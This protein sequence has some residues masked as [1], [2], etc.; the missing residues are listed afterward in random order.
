MIKSKFLPILYLSACLSVTSCSSQATDILE[1]QATSFCVVYDPSNW[2]FKTRNIDRA[3]LYN[4][5][6][7]NAQSAIQAPELKAVFAGYVAS[8]AGTDFADYIEAGFSQVLDSPWK[9]KPMREFEK[10][11]AAPIGIHAQND[12]HQNSAPIKVII[13]Q[14]GLS[15]N[16]TPLTDVTPESI[17]KA[18]S[19][20]LKDAS[21]AHEAKSEN[22]NDLVIEVLEPN[23]ALFDQLLAVAGKLRIERISL[24]E[25]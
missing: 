3:D 19:A 11:M 20:A 4:T 18:L 24:V 10:A 8:D 25:H 21:G 9:C 13:N 14:Q 22:A 15:I 17:S 2:E 16:D 7:I 12:K 5:L 1:A 6:A 23:Q